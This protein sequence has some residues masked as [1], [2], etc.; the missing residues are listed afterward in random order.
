MSMSGLRSWLKSW[1]AGGDS[2]R[3]ATADKDWQCVVAESLMFELDMQ[4][5]NLEQHYWELEQEERRAQTGV[6]YSW[7]ISNDNRCFQIAHSERMQL[8]NLS[9]LV[10]P[11]E[12][13]AIIKSFRTCLLQEPPLSEV[14]ALFKQCITQTLEERPKEETFTEWV[15]TRTASMISS[16]KLLRP[17]HQVSPISDD[18]D[19]ERQQEAF[20][21]TSFDSSTLY[22]KNS[23]NNIY[24]F[25]SH[26]KHTS[27]YL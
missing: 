7:L 11:E 18:I 3:G 24:D 5:R 13:S 12:C 6:D 14:A 17:S 20:P 27:H 10:K 25:P 26:N 22:F 4:V 9:Q 23:H 15:S 8:H 1:L 21:L 2:I 16:M 19:I